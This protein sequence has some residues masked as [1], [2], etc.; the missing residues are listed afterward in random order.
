VPE[1]PWFDLFRFERLPQQRVFKEVDLANAKIIRGARQYRF[2]LSSI[3]GVSGPLG[4]GAAASLLPF[5]AIAV[6]KATSKI[7]L[8]GFA[9]SS[10]VWS[11]NVD[12]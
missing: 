5:A 1:Q 9:A 7:N 11:I 10:L 2:I 4:T 8:L 3:S 6:D 12:P